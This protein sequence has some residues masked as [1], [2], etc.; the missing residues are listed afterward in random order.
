M[1]KKKGNMQW[2]S[3]PLTQRQYMSDG[4]TK[5]DITD[6][7]G[8]ACKNKESV[9][10]RLEDH[11]PE[12]KIPDKFIRGIGKYE[13]DNS[14][15]CVILAIPCFQTTT[16]EKGNKTYHISLIEFEKENEPWPFRVVLEEAKP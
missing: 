7:I 3:S 2:Q 14:G 5:V 4:E 9:F 12:L 15:R 6:V 13:E 10:L 11:R 1:K 16:D 8:F